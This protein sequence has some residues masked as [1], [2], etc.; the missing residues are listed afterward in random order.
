[1][2]KFEIP[3]NTPTNRITEMVVAQLNEI[4]ERLEYLEQPQYEYYSGPADICFCDV[5]YTGAHRTSC[6]LYG[7][8]VR[9]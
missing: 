6:N 2:K 7:K 5:N 9:R 3:P 4:L 8:K 1:V